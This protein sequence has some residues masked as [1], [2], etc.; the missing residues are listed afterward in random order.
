MHGSSSHPPTWLAPQNVHLLLR[1]IHWCLV[2]T[3]RVKSTFVCL[4]YK[5]ICSVQPQFPF[6]R[7]LGAL[8]V[9]RE[10]GFMV[11]PKHLLTL[12]F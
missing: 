12:H 5:V 4:A 9:L 10:I 2:I 7:T 6:H 11:S 8:A 1:G 3:H